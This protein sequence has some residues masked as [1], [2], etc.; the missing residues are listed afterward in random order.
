MER[1]G[2]GEQ[3]AGPDQPHGVDQLHGLVAGHRVGSGRVM[4]VSAKGGDIEDASAMRGVC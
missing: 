1:G 4:A 2:G 3:P